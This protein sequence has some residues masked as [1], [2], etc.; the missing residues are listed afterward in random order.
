MCQLI[1]IMMIAFK[2]K[3]LTRSYQMN[4][5]PSILVSL[6]P[7]VFLVILLSIN[8]MIFSDDSSYG[9]N[10]LALFCAAMLTAFIGVF[11]LKLRY[12]DIEKKAVASISISLQAI[13]ILLIV[14]PLIS[15]WILSGVVPA[16]I[17][18]GLELIN[19]HFFLPVSVI[20][21][22]IVSMA[23]GSSWSTVGTIGIALVGVGQALAI[24]EGMVAGAIVS[25]AYF[26]DKLSPLSDTTNLAPAMAGTELFKHI[27]HMLYTTIPSITLTILI[28]LII[29]IFYQGEGSDAEDIMTL[30]TTL[31]NTFNLSPLLFALPLIVF[32]LVKKKV[33]AMPALFAGVLLGVVCALIFQMDLLI[34]L[35]DGEF[36]FSSFYKIVTEAAFA[37]YKSSTGDAIVD[38]LL[39]R[40]GMS[41]ML[42]TVWLILMAMV[43]GGMMEVTGM[44][45][46]LALGILKF[47][48]GVT[49][50]VAST[51]ATSIFLNLTTS[52]QYIS[53]VV[54]GGMFKKS[55]RDYNLDPK[56]LSRAVE[57]SATVTSVLIPWNT[58]GAYFSS[59]L[60]VATL[61]YL[62]FAFFNLISPLMSIAIAASGKT[63]DPLLEEELAEE[64]H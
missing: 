30:K 12:G 41:S 48:R 1:N 17:Y 55:Y 57:D 19:P 9:P 60:G 51:V 43:F 31:E 8:V 32:V 56:N 38:K 29:G 20:I 64:V 16:M 14:G 28:F 46:S 35:S 10:Q 52:D 59:V 11:K 53:I 22:S 5:A 44:L 58:C 61:T 15:L 18:Y 23:T 42:N 25:G 62:P 13:F 26:G 36:S 47:V 27:R 7:V 50:L 63:M 21:C 34:K 24:P 37:G 3:S 39:S 2:E 45:N 40:G 4:R 54:T 6:I 49:S 33:P